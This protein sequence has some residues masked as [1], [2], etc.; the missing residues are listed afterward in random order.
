ME[1]SLTHKKR[2]TVIALVLCFTAFVLSLLI[3]M[4][5][6]IQSGIIRIAEKILGRNLNHDHWHTVLAHTTVNFLK[7]TAKGSAGIAAIAAAISFI[8]RERSWTVLGILVPMG[9][10]LVWI[11]YTGLSFAGLL[12]PILFLLLF[13]GIYSKKR[14]IFESLLITIIA[15]TSGV[16]LVNN[17]LSFF[18]GITFTVLLIVYF[19]SSLLLFLLL[20]RNGDSVYKL[21][22]EVSEKFLA[23]YRKNEV[24]ATITAIVILISFLG[25]LFCDFRNGDSLSYHLVRIAEWARQHSVNFYYP[26]AS[27][28]LTAP[29]LAEY[30]ALHSYI[31]FRSDA[32]INLIQHFSYCISALCIFKTCRKLGIHESLCYMGTLLFLTMPIAF[33]ESMTTQVDL[34]STLLVLIFFYYIL[35]LVQC[36]KIEFAAAH[37][38]NFVLAAF[39]FGLGYLAKPSACLPMSIVLLYFAIASLVKKQ[40]NLPVYIRYILLCSAIFAIL[41]SETFIRNAYYGS[42]DT[43]EVSSEIIIGTRSP[44][45]VLLNF[46]KNLCQLLK[47]SKEEMLEDFCLHLANAFNIDINDPMISFYKDFF[48]LRSYLMDNANSPLVVFLGILLLPVFITL[49]C[50]SEKTANSFSAVLFLAAFS[51]PLI[52]RWQPWGTRLML[53]SISLLCIFIPS[54]LNQ[55]SSAMFK[56]T[57]AGLFMGLIIVFL[58]PQVQIHDFQFEEGARTARIRFRD[59]NSMSESAFKVVMQDLEH[60]GIYIHS[61]GVTSTGRCHVYQFLYHLNR[62]GIPACQIPALDN[63]KPLIALLKNKSAWDKYLRH[64]ISSPDMIILIAIGISPPDE[65]TYQNEHYKIYTGEQ[66]PRVQKLE[67]KDSFIF[68]KESLW[69]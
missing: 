54:V 8:R 10:A 64:S 38:E 52:L 60:S 53:P 22:K 69:K 11:S 25:A 46:T 31:L 20:H 47:F 36:Q 5:P 23:S 68:I 51:I 19:C 27:I 67:G 50:R 45:F 7:T 30:L 15:Y 35:N 21:L 12:I 29:V 66:F 63:G 62:I 43:R 2:L 13:L 18:S 37:T 59:K 9:I 34:L 26:L 41:V 4:I 24:P 3:S 28:Q 42:I 33:A 1:I 14:E 55:F 32:F 49:A 61:A 39:C 65:L 48:L 56:K 40:M 44:K 17:I 58:V 16:V 57:V 6:G